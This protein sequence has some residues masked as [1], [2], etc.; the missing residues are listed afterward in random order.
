MKGKP[1]D[2]TPLPD[3]LAELHREI[4]LLKASEA[5]QRRELEALQKS[6]AYYRT[7]TQHASDLTIIVDRTG[8]IAYVNPSIERILGYRP[9]ELIGRSGFDFIAPADFPRA[10]YDF[11]R[12]ILT[13]RDVLIPNAFHVRHKDGSERALE[14]VGS[15]LL[16]HPVVLGF[17]MN[18]RD[19]SRQK[20]AEAERNRYR[21]S[22]ES[23]VAEH[24]SE[25]AKVNVQLLAELDERQ[26][27]EEA[28]R[29]NEQRFR[30]LIQKSSDI[31]SILDGEGRFIYNSPAVET[32]LGYQ[33]ESLIGRPFL[34]FV[35]PD[36]RERLRGRFAEVLQRTNPGTPSVFR[37]RK[38]NGS[39]RYLEALASN[40]LSDPAINGIVVTSRDITERKRADEE[41]KQ[42][43][44]RLQRAQKMESLGTLAGGVAHDLNNILGVLV[45]YAELVLMEL[46]QGTPAHRRVARILQSSQRAAKIIEDLLTLARRGV[47]SSEVVQ[48]NQVIR[49][50]L[51]T[52]EFDKLKSYHPGVAFQTTFAADLKNIKGS[53]VHL[54]KTVMNLVSN[55]A[56]AITQAGVVEIRTRNHRLD[57]SLPGYDGVQAGEYVVVSVTDNGAGISAD[58]LEKIFEPFYTKKVMGRSGT[59]L[60]LA[61][62]WGTVKDHAGYIDVNSTNGLGSTFSL[63]FPATEEPLQA[64]QIEIPLDDY[65]SQ[66][67][68]ILVVD[69]VEEQREMA[70]S[71]LTRLGYAVQAVDSGEAALARLKEHPADLLVLDM[72]MDPGIDGLET[73][74]RVLEIRPDQRAVI[75]SGFSETE[76]VRKALRLG[77]GAY[78]KKPYALDQIGPAIREALQKKKRRPRNSHDKPPGT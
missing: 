71:L 20:N 33:P 60:G 50:Y 14:G 52:P 21:Q 7:I 77:A 5:R 9:E 11:G 4:A 13:G 38:G 78:V 17:V 57:E 1:G 35:H 28:L 65:R 58:D 3:A 63:Y 44:V 36:E 61:V 22:L 16:A 25:L 42:L 53:P 66:G 41:R 51:K 67:E 47:E 18:V 27:M 10:V 48:L 24:S 37:C 56:E 39:W 23:L 32:T 49:D 62:V 75:V 46:P 2:F 73:Y 64:E 31:I 72:I 26:R 12:A 15:N 55:A 59:G 45:G 70:V 76:R 74:R 19:V 40:L 8:T 34:E 54:T 69:D 43:K 30:T 29:A 6:E 68:S